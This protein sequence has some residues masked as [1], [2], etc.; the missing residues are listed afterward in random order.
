M[1]LWHYELVRALPDNQ[2]VSQ[3][4][5]LCA[6]ASR[7]AK[8]GYPNHLLV[9]E[10]M[11]YEHTEILSYAEEVIEEMYH[12]G[13]K[14]NMKVYDTFYQNILSNKDKFKAIKKSNNGKFNGWHNYR[15]YWQCYFNLQEKYDRHGISK[16]EWQRIASNKRYFVLKSRYIMVKSK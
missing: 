12:R 11:N 4:R 7:I 14:I 1:R 13:F 15:Y 6:I 9:N 3:W 5:E 8:I 16:S 10:V 2:L